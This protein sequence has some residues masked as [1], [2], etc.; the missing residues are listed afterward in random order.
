MHRQSASEIRAANPGLPF[1]LDAAHGDATSTSDRGPR[2]YDLVGRPLTCI[3][4]TCL[5]VD[6]IEEWLSRREP[7]EVL[8]EKRD[9]A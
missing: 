4:K 8:S 7:L 9:Q 3:S 2:R 5:F 1:N 6:H